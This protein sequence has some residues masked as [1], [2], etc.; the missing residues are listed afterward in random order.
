MI[1]DAVH[2][3]HRGIAI[4]TGAVLLA[5]CSS[6]EGSTEPA[7]PTARESRSSDPT[8]DHTEGAPSPTRRG[9]TPSSP[10]PE[11]PTSEGDD[12]SLSEFSTGPRETRDYP[13]I[14]GTF[15]DVGHLT[16][17]RHGV[18]KELERIVFEF[19]GD[20][21]PAVITNG[22]SAGPIVATF[23]STQTLTIPVEYHLRD[24]ICRF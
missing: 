21:P 7:T 6:G 23:P 11:G 18:H 24:P 5:A 2:R 20:L 15:E 14:E 22:I 9:S 19:S 10:D 12:S 3:V 17:I 8:P 4:T 13:S 1:S 16:D